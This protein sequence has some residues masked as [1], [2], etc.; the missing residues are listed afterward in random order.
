MN[1]SSRE[2]ARD[3]TGERL[4]N[5]MGARNKLEQGTK[6][7]NAGSAEYVQPRYRGL[8]TGLKDRKPL[9]NP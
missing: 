3:V 9:E 1:S 4:A 7:P 2:V 6:T 5:V 8:Q